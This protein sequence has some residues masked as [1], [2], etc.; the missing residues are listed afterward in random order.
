M[1]DHGESAGAVVRRNQGSH[2]DSQLLLIIGLT[3]IIHLIGTLAYAFRIAGIRT[4]HIAIA[5]SLFN[6][7]VLVSRT[8]NSFQGPFLAKRVDRHP[9]LSKPAGAAPSDR[10]SRRGHPDELLRQ[11]ALDG[12]GFRVPRLQAAGMGPFP[13]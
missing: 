9:P 4:G 8:S 13:V 2:M 7:L 11:R 12:G 5:F 3:F 1:H 6:I 10:C